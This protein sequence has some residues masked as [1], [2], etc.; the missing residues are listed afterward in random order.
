MWNKTN[1][2]SFESKNS[3]KYARV[4]GCLGIPSREGW[5]AATAVAERQRSRSAGVGFVAVPPTPGLMALAP[6]G[7]FDSASPV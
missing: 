1:F 2:Y 3:G 5:R 4:N 7:G 6:P